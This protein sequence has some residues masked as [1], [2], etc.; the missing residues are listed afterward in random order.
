MKRV[1]EI[2]F[3]ALGGAGEERGDLRVEIGEIAFA[4]DLGGR[5]G[6]VVDADRPEHAARL[7]ADHH[8]RLER[9]MHLHE[10]RDKG[11]LLCE[12][13]LVLAGLNLHRKLYD[14]RHELFL[15]GSVEERYR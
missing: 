5:L 12:S 10:G 1:Q 13:D 6:A 8:H 11:V 15:V 2:E 9:R 14:S 4:V 7:V 3:D